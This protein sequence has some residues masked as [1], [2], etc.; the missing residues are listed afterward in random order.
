MHGD[1]ASPF[2]SLGACGFFAGG[3]SG[4]N[5]FDDAKNGVMSVSLGTKLVGDS[6]KKG[7]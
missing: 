4:L 7:H 3:R 1:R 5:S 6:I 2:T